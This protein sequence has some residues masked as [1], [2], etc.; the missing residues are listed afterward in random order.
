MILRFA[1]AFGYADIV[2]QSRHMMRSGAVQREITKA[3]AKLMTAP[4]VPI[5]SGE[6]P[7]SQF[8]AVL[9]SGDT[10]LK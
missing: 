5:P 8:S 2:N 9:V 1:Y 6:M 3:K 4:T 10:N 7:K